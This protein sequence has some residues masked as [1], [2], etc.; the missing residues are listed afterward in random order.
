MRFFAVVVGAA[1]SACGGASSPGDP[2]P[3]TLA[4]A[5]LVLR[6]GDPLALTGVAGP[7]PAQGISRAVV[8]A[9]VDAGGNLWA[10]D[11]THLYLLRPSAGAV[12]SFDAGDGLRP[13]ELRAV[14]GGLEGVA[15]VGHAG[16]GDANE[17]PEWMRHT[18]GVSKAVLSGADLDV[19]PYELSSPPGLYAQYPDGRY[20]LRTVHRVHATRTGPRA[21]DAWFGC[22]HGL[23]LVPASGRFVLEHHHPGSCKPDPVT[24]DCS[25][26]TG[27]VPA[28][29][30]TPEGDVWFG[31]TYGVGLLAYATSLG[32][33][34]GAE[35]VRNL[36]LWSHPLKPNTH[37]SVDVVGLAALPDGT[38][39]AASA[40]SG[41]ARRR[42]DGTVDVLDAA[43]GLPT[44][45][46]TDLASD[47]AGQL[48][49]GTRE[50]GL[51]RLDPVGGEWRRVTGL[52]SRI[53]RVKDVT[54]DGGPP[55]LLVVTDGRVVTGGVP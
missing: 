50:Q 34:W 14:A 26:H 30:F 16:Q 51:V 38:L 19:T 49:L 44:N 36:P 20:K 7:M 13:D 45:R 3:T 2:T 29:A 8:D 9:D 11:A 12:E 46:L 31:G 55:R 35:P 37:G 22:N 25:L 41:L 18:G 53:D 15:W 24:G 23:A 42:P 5:V 47:A 10:V 6:E 54:R 40:H 21:G 17:D 32:D 43:A 1:L 27:D 33:F 52:G 39:W 28:V 4:P 48:W